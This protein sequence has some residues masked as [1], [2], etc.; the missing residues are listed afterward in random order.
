[1]EVKTMHV[2]MSARLVKPNESMPNVVIDNPQATKDAELKAQ[3]TV[4]I[5]SEGKAKSDKER[6]EFKALRERGEPTAA[7]DKKDKDS[8]EEKIK[9]LREKINE[10]LQKLTMARN[11]GEDEEKIKMLEAE[12]AALQAQL[13][14]LLEK[15]LQGKSE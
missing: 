13:M 5:S 2:Q 14:S 10:L 11:Q 15:Q 7:E 12:M 4:S 3:D 8:V 6:D 9:E 1:M